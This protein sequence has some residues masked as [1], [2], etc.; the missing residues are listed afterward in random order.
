M[1]KTLSVTYGLTAYVLFLCAFLYLIAFSLNLAP[2]SISGPATRPPLAAALIDLVL[3]TLF[4]VQHSIMAR[5]AFKRWW[6]RFVPP[7]LERSTFVLIATGLVALLIAC[8]QPIE[9]DLWNVT[10]AGMILI[11]AVSLLGYMAVP[12]VSFLTDHF[13][14][15]GV[16]QVAQYALDHA[17]SRPLF[18]EKSIYRKVRHPMMLGFLVAFW[19]APHMTVGHLLFATAMTAYILVGAYFEERTL[20]V[21]HGHAYRDY[22][23][24]VP[25]LLPWSSAADS[26]SAVESRGGKAMTKEAVAMEPREIIQNSEATVS[27]PPGGG[28]RFVGYSVMGLTFASGHVLALRRFTASS[29]G[30]AFTS[31]WHRAPSGRWTFHSTVAPEQ[32]CAR[33]F[34]E[35]IE[36]NVRAPIRIEWQSPTELKVVVGGQWPINW[37]MK[38]GQTRA[39]RIV[40]AVGRV[41]PSR[42][43]RNR[44]VLRG[45]S[46]A[47]GVALGAGP[48]SLS[49]LTPNGQ[50]FLA[51]PQ[52]LWIV[53]ASRAIING[54][55][56]GEMGPLA[57]QPRLGDFRIPQRGLFGWGR[58]FIDGGGSAVLERSQ[59]AA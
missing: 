45:M 42:L 32:S 53:T 40:N 37:Y 47:A 17:P 55:D 30:P 54:V 35:Q 21:E 19:A 5:P 22:Q 28:D 6:T 8:W 7:Q 24:R 23:S 33:Y 14:L 10:G 59:R 38:L 13:Y 44:F 46:L 29:L 1:K 56:A 2:Q 52:Q 49:G 50:R 15:F 27:L 25:K 9:G 4:G 12:A 20:A 58:S 31:V 34:G 18:R 3:I 43:R 36:R 41:V 51:N 26:S 48:I 57:K 11:S 16:R 39:S